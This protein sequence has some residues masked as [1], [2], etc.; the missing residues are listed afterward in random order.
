[1][2]QI[3]HPVQYLIIQKKNKSC[4]FISYFKHKKNNNFIVF[5]PGN[6]FLSGPRGNI[7]GLLNGGLNSIPPP[8]RPRGSKSPRPMSLNGSIILYS[9][10]FGI[11]NG[12]I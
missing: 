1:M 10:I 4:K 2:D 3:E 6:G 9:N 5:K 12:I 8:P 7:F 11:E